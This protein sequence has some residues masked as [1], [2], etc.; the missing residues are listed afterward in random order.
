[1][2]RHVEHRTPPR[3]AWM[4]DHADGLGADDAVLVGPNG[5]IVD[6]RRQQQPKG[7]DAIEQTGGRVRSDSDSLRR[8]CQFVA[9]VAGCLDT[10]QR[11][12]N[13]VR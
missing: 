6:E 5:F 3:E 2:A 4:I 1:M 11:Q 9:L 8:H 10:A 7:L 12:M 13:D